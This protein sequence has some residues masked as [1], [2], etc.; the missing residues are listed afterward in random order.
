MDTDRRLTSPVFSVSIFIWL[1][2]AWTLNACVPTPT[3]TPFIAP[4]TTQPTET[5]SPPTPRPVPQTTASPIPTATATPIQACTDNLSY[6]ADLTVPDGTP[7]QPGELVDKQWQVQNSGTCDWD[8][9][10][11]LKL[12]GGEA[13]GA[14]SEQALYPAKAGTQVVIQ[15]NFYAPLVPGV[16]SSSWQAFNPDGEPFGDPVYMEIVVGE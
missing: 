9:E 3:P 12:V 1:M 4:D 14:A 10:Y 15:I 11:R 8:S 2:L 6:Q 13:M 5:A 16:Y 7:V